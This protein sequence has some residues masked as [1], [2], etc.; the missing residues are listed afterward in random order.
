MQQIINF[1]LRNKN[2]LLYAFLFFIALVFT[3]NSRSYHQSKFFN[4]ANWISG[5]L[6]T[7]SSNISGYFG[8]KE[9]NLELVAENERLRRLLFNGEMTDTVALDTSLNRYDVVSG[10]VI[11]NSFSG[12][13]NY[14][15]INKG[16]NDG[17]TQDM[18]VIS[19]NGILGIVENTSA[20]FATVQSILNT[21]SNIN[22]KLKG[23]DYF[24]SLTWNTQ[25]Y[26]TVQ[27]VD[28]P[29]LAPIA[30]GDTIVTGSM[31]NIFPEHIPIGTITGF[32]LTAS[33]SFYEIEVRLFNDMGNLRQVYIIKD[34]LK[35][36]IE[37]LQ[38][39]T[40]NAQ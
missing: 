13:R 32:E 34:R 3:I 16:S 22:A 8:L 25:D 26:N 23:T 19:P 10:R 36:E 21:K 27:L 14:I 29:R 35:A 33:E 30:V 38:S 24:G 28:I 4:S 9:D 39:K 37:A 40:E 6:Y 7:F 2:S 15:T 11:K 1:L 18:G 12:P 5:N 20:N 31:S 17:L